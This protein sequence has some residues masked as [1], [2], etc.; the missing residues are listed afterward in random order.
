VKDRVTEGVEYTLYYLNALEGEGEQPNFPDI[1]TISYEGRYLDNE[2][3]SAS[4]SP[5][6]FD[7]TQVVNG[8]QDALVEFKGATSVSSNPDGT[9]NFENYG[10]GAVFMQSGLG[11]YVNPP[12][13]SNIPLYSELIFT[14]Q[15]YEVE[16]GDQ[17]ND[18]VP[19]VVEDVNG[20]NIEE[21]DDTDGD[22]AANYLDP[23]DDN[24]GRPTRDEIEIDAQ[25]NITYPD[26][27]NDGVPDY[28]DR[29]S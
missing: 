20:N 6:K 18:G 24:D 21:D 15:L 27:D 22:G 26:V 7:L 23:D 8:L 11:Y 2:L 29:D 13:G 1:T 5:V 16:T 3:F 10:V 25:G 9:V 12:A 19:S 17:D 4:V 28:L 14:F